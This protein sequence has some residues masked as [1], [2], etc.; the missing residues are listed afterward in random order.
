MPTLNHCCCASSDCAG[1][2]Y[3]A[4]TVVE[5]V[6]IMGVWPS[7]LAVVYSGP[8][9]AHSVSYTHGAGA[10]S[11]VSVP[12][13]VGSWSVSMTGTGIC[14]DAAGFSLSCGASGAATIHV[15][16]VNVYA[17]GAFFWCNLSAPAV[18]ESC[19]IS[20]TVTYPGG[21]GSDSFDTSTHGPVATQDVI[22]MAIACGYSLPQSIT[23]TATLTG[24]AWSCYNG[25]TASTTIDCST[26]NALSFTFTLKSGYTLYDGASPIKLP[27]HYVDGKG[28]ASLYPG[29][30]DTVGLSWLY[31]DPVDTCGTYTNFIGGYAATFPTAGLECTLEGDPIRRFSV[32]NLTQ[33]VT[34]V[35]SPT[36]LPVWGGG[37][38]DYYNVRLYMRGTFG[39]IVDCG[40][41]PRTCVFTP[42]PAWHEVT[43][44]YCT[45]HSMPR[46]GAVAETGTFVGCAVIY[47]GSYATS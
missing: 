35:L 37:F 26:S 46:C 6:A 24:S 11:Y 7:D 45:A 10:S 1:S 42:D 27:I 4:A 9:G 15:R 23:A 32:V 34:V 16:P 18:G 33:S 39:D 40:G 43:Q 31:F 2:S 3:I 13:A 30:W 36:G 14:S 21:T 12:T 17:A 29:Y 8:D 38:P 5:C 28:S 22:T 44:A 25:A 19:P 41:T 20:W 47:F